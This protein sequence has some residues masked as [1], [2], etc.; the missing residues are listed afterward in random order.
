[1]RKTGGMNRCDCYYLLINVVAGIDGMDFARFRLQYRRRS[2]SAD[3]GG[4]GHGCDQHIYRADYQPP[5]TASHLPDTGA[6]TFI[7]NA[8]L[9]LIRAGLPTCSFPAR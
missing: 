5:F 1:M 9:L 2:V 7:I 8:I 3:H 4:R 6:F